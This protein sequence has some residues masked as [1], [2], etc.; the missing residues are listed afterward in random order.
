MKK[1]SYITILGWMRKFGLTPSQLIAYAIVYGFSQD[2][3]GRYVAGP[4]YIAD[5]AG[6]SVVT[7]KRDLATLVSLGLIRKI[8]RPG[9]GCI[10]F[11]AYQVD[12][13]RVSN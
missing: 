5:W 4:S 9:T 10:S 2:G 8:V 13:R 12:L 7:A 1:E 6:V 11:N 3:K